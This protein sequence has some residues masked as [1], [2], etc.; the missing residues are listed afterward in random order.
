M[1]S[2]ERLRC[3]GTRGV[4]YETAFHHQSDIFGVLCGGIHARRRRAGNHQLRQ[5]ST[6]NDR[7]RFAQ[8]QRLTTE[9][10]PGHVQIAV[11]AADGALMVV[12]DELK[13]GARCR[14]SLETA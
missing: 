10:T 12:W 5:Y 4:L 3:R 9:G 2:T 8:R 14:R 7:V 6:S 1:R 13:G 11:N